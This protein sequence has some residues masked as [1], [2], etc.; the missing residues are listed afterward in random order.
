VSKGKGYHAIYITWFTKEDGLRRTRL[1]YGKND[2]AT[3]WN[4]YCALCRVASAYTVQLRHPDG[5]TVLAFHEG[6]TPTEY[7]AREEGITPTEY[8]EREHAT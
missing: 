6:L 7:Y 3:A 1:Q 8:W 4:V 2:A 5:H